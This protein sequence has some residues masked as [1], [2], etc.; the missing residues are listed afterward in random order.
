MATIGDAQQFFNSVKDKS[1]LDSY[2]KNDWNNVYNKFANMESYQTAEWGSKVILG[3]LVKGSDEALK[4]LKTLIDRRTV[5]QA[6]FVNTE[7]TANQDS[8]FLKLKSI[9]NKLTFF[10]LILV[11]IGLFLSLQTLKN[12]R[13]NIFQNFDELRF[14]KLLKH[15]FYLTQII[16][17]ILTPALLG[18]L[19]A[20]NLLPAIKMLL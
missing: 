14:P 11:A 10:I 19:I 3:I 16:S 15:Q 7:N 2:E 1:V 8:K 5:A 18:Y 20:V 17:L 9:L 6:F 13:K 4:S 12:N